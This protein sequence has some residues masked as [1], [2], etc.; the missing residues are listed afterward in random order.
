MRDS[1]PHPGADP[2]SAT[3][4]LTRPDAQDTV[5]IA[6]RVPAAVPARAP[7]G[8]SG[9]RV[10]T[11]DALR[12]F[13]LFGILLVNIPHVLGMPSEVGGAEAPV[14]RALDLFVQYRF[15]VIFALLFGIGFGI[16]LQRATRK[17]PRPRLLLARRLAVLF[18]LGGLHQ[19]LHPGE[20]LLF[21]G[22]LGVA[23][24]LPLSFAPRWA[25]LLVALVLPISPVPG[26]LVLGYALA[27]YEIPQTLHARRNQLAVVFAVSAGLSVPALLTQLYGPR[28]LGFALTTVVAGLCLATAYSSGLALLLRTRAGRP[29]SAALEPLG[30]MALTNYVSATLL[31]VSAGR[32]IG[33]ADSSSWWTMLGFAV[34]VIAVQAVWSR[35]WLAH[36]RYGPLEWA[37]RCLTWWNLPPIRLRGLPAS[38]A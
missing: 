36:F 17:H 18:P 3:R 13:A 9:Q 7:G 11:L 32:L 27:R 38:A 22:V 19:L 4:R 1:A 15:N 24:L 33:L 8:S 20:Y 2:W 35:L 25:A 21:Y 12:G 28:D 23:L 31:M 37:W 34:A 26:A 14:R 10:T 16:F 29:I 30:R 6:V 5:P